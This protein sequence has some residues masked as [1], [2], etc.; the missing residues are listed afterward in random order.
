MTSANQQGRFA[1]T[2]N[3]GRF[4]AFLLENTRH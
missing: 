2:S 1:N 3:D 4:Q